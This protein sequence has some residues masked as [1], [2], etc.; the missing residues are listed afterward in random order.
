MMGQHVCSP[1]YNMKQEESFFFE[2]AGTVKV[3]RR[4]GH[5]GPRCPFVSSPSSK[6]YLAKGDVM[7]FA[8]LAE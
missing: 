7:K 3:S 6:N 5:F 1:M 4:I 2:V 8:L